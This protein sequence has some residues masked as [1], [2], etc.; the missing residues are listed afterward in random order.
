MA[1][2]RGPALDQGEQL[3]A[4]LVRCHRAVDGERRS[5]AWFTDPAGNVLS[6]VQQT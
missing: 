4:H 1:D 5:I 2:G 3:M 6:I